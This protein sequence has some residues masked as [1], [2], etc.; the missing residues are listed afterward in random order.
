MHYRLFFSMSL[1]F[2]VHRFS[3]VMFS[4]IQK[5]HSLQCL[6][7]FFLF[8]ALSITTTTQKKICRVIIKNSSNTTKKRKKY[9]TPTQTHTYTHTNSSRR[10]SHFSH[11]Q[12]IDHKCRSHSSKSVQNL[13]DFEFFSHTEISNRTVKIYSF[14]C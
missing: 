14:L 3:L 11:T 10:K 2:D 6:L 13:K 5:T 9:L 7:S 8:L 4:V 12:F 1:S